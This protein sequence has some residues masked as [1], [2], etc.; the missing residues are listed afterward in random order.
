[1]EY[2]L[3]IEFSRGIMIYFLLSFLYWSVEY[4]QKRLI[5]DSES[6][7]DDDDL[8]PMKYEDKYLLE[9]DNLKEGEGDPEVEAN[10]DN[11]SNCFVIEKTPIGNVLMNY[12]SKKETFDYFSDMSIPYRYLLVVCRKYVMQFNCVS[13][14]VNSEIKELEN[15]EPDNKKNLETGKK[16]VFAK[17]K[18]YNVD[19]KAPLAGPG[20]P[21]NSIPQPVHQTGPVLL[22]DKI[23]RFS[24]QGKF[25]N[26]S[27]LKKVD[28]KLVD[29]KFAMTFAEFKK[30]KNL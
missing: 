5:D 10:I 3:F 9:L 24:Y 17:F 20:P 22:K 8:E 4:E 23:N 6:D 11:L 27:I 19:S 1:M 16:N 18:N 2:S 13:L 26:F 7:I 25:N 29:K 28:R 12:N 21:K 14:Y 15:K 30:L